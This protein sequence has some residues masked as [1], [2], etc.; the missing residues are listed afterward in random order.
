MDRWIVIFC[1][2]ATALLGEPLFAAGLLLGF[3]V[4]LYRATPSREERDD[5]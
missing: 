3:E 1:A 2:V 5:Q 4:G